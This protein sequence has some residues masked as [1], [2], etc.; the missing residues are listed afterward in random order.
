MGAF[1][2]YLMNPIYGIIGKI[3]KAGL[4]PHMQKNTVLN[5]PFNL[6]NVSKRNFFGSGFPICTKQIHRSRS[7]ISY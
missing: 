3:P 4:R 5:L 2:K 1:S 6:H 7:T